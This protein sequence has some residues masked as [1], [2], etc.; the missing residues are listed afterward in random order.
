[1]AVRAVACAVDRAQQLDEGAEIQLQIAS[2]GVLRFAYQLICWCVVT[3][4]AG[5]LLTIAGFMILAALVP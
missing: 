4:L 2:P 5:W 1:M 3:V